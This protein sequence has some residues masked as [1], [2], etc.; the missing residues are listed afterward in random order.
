VS[1][2]AKHDVQAFA[3]CVAAFVGSCAPSK[4]VGV[5]VMMA[6]VMIVMLNAGVIV[7]AYS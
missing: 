4:S 5:I 7:D 1:S 3:W 2:A 6:V